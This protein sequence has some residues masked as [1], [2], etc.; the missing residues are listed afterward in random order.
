MYLIE[1]QSTKIC[2][3]NYIY[4]YLNN[5]EIIQIYARY[6]NSEITLVTRMKHW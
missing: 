6:T 2:K 5:A 4:K 3:I 1:I